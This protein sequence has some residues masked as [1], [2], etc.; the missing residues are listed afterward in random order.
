MKRSLATAPA[1]KPVT[2][3]EAK[4]HMNVEHTEDDALITSLIAAATD[5]AEQ[6]T[7]RA[8]I[9]QVWDVF[10]DCFEDVLCIPMWPVASVG[11]VKYY[12]ADDTEQTLSSSSYYVDTYSYPIRITPVSTWPGTATRP[13][14]VTV[15]ITAGAAAAPD[16]V[17]SAILMLVGHLY[18]NR[19]AGS[20]VSISE[21]PLGV[22][23]LLDAHRIITV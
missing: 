5:Y 22:E 9:T 10:F 17:A 13:N 18:E 7:G 6:Q 20:P 12:D 15:R 8:L 11:S 4:L 3:S 21:V 16:A 23:A 14:A 1:S 2:L 19:E